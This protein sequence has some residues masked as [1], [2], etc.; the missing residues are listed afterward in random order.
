MTGSDTQIRYRRGSSRTRT[1]LQGATILDFTHFS[2]ASSRRPIDVAVG[3]LVGL[4]H[5][6]EGEAFEEIAHSVHATGIGL[7][8]LARALVA[9]A[10]RTADPVPHYAVA[11]ELWGDLVAL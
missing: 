9:V 10:S 2:E 11:L 8:S 4:R 1:D 7:G 5:C 3:V 6:T